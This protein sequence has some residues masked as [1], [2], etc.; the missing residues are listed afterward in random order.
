MA[1]RA[2]LPVAVLGAVLVAIGFVGAVVYQLQPW[3]S[4]PDDDSPAA[5]AMLPED[6]AAFLAFVVVLLAGCVT[7]LVSAV[8]RSRRPR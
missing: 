4:C 2:V 8:L 1:R 7:L 6:Y 5:C 3:R